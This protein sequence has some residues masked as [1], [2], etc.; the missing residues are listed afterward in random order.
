[1]EIRHKLGMYKVQWRGL[2]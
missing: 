2:C 1:M